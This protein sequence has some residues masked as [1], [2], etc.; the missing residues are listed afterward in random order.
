MDRDTFLV[1]V[2]ILIMVVFE[3]Y[4]AI[5]RGDPSRLVLS[6]PLVSILTTFLLFLHLIAKAEKRLTQSLER[7]LPELVYMESRKEVEVETT[8]LAEQANEYIIATGGRSRNQ[9]YLKAIEHKVRSGEITYWRLIFDEQLT[10]EVCEHICSLLSLPNV[11]IGQIENR[12]Y[13]NM[14]VVDTGLI[15]ALPVPGHG[16][17]MGI[18][19]PNSVSAHRVF[20]YLM[21]VFPNAKRVSSPQE[22]KA[23]CEQCA[24]FI[25]SGS[26]N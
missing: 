11:M 2:S 1:I 3:T 13:G 19:I 5:S 4:T 26:S 21:M 15:I 6:I 24:G 16:G 25:K 20:R 10:H 9:E 12:G 22:V 14:L 18:K 7:R 8:K 17:L 23:H